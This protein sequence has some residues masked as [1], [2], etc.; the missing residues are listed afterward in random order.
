MNEITY[1]KGYSFAAITEA[2]EY[3]WEQYGIERDIP[4]E[5]LELML[6]DEFPKLTEHD[7]D[8][9]FQQIAQVSI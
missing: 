1:F 7:A 8:M 9:I 2:A 6:C 5:Q 4:L 3:L